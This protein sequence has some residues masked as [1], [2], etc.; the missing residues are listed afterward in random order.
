MSGK[1][2]R[3]ITAEIRANNVARGWRPAEGGPG[4]N[5]FGDYIALLHTEVAE[6]TEAYRDWGIEDATATPDWENG[7]DDPEDGPTS[8]DFP[9]PKPEG[10]GSE[11]A[12]V[13]IRA[14]DMA[15]VFGYTPFD[16]DC[17]IGDIDPLIP[18]VIR[19]AQTRPARNASFGDWMWG[20]HDAVADMGSA[21]QIYFSHLIRAIAAVAERYEIDLTAEYERKMAYNRTRPFQHGGRTMAKVEGSA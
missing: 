16:M 10:V 8:A 9:L 19:A 15:D 18:P 12:D 4:E 21:P 5:T 20:L 14:L 3:E 11:L 7:D 2:L 1:S 17:E 6:M 13:L